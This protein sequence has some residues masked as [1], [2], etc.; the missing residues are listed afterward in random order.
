MPTASPAITSFNGGALSP[1]LAGRTDFAKY[2]NGCRDLLNFIPTVQGPA[3]QRAGTRFVSEVKN[4]ANR[5]WLARF[6]YNVDN[7]YV[8]EF[9]DLYV[10]FYTQHG[11]LESPPGTP[12]EV[13]TP[14]TL[15]SLFNADNTCRLRL[16]Q[17]G[18]FLYIF[19]GDFEPRILK[20]TSATSFTLTEY[21]PDG[22]P[23]K[24][25][26]DTAT[27]VYASAETGTGI[28]LTASAAIF[29]AGHVGS[30]FLL[31]AKS[32]NSV[33]AWEVAKAVVATDRRRVS[34]RVY[35][36]L[37]A[38]T[39]GTAQPVHTKGA[40]Y[41]GD[42][43]VQWEFRDA[44]FG[45]V[46]IT[47]IGGGGTTATVDVV[48]RLPADVVSAGNATTRWA[49]ASWSSAEGWPT[50]VAFFRERLA[51]ARRDQIWL[52]VASAFDDMSARNSNG[53]VA[54]DQAISL[55][56][57]SGE[58]NDVQWLLPGK[59]LLAGTAGGE[60][61]IGELSNGEPLGPSNIRVRLQSRF[62][63]RS[64]VPVQAGPAI[65]FVQRAGKKVRE[66]AY[67]F[68]SDGYQSTDRTALAEHITQSGLIDLDYAQEPDSVVWCARADGVLVGFTWNAEQNVWA[69]HPHSLSGQVES[70]A[71]IPSPDGSRNELWL[72]VKR[73][74]N[75]A[76]KRYVEFIEASW[77]PEQ[78]QQDAFYVDCGLGYNGAPATTISGLGHLEGQ[79]VAVLAD[80]S[81][82]PQRTVS[83]GA[84]TL[85]TA[86]S[87]VQ[88]GL[89]MTARLS[90]MR[91]DAGAATGTAQA[92]TKRT[93]RLSVRLQNTSSGKLGPDDDHLDELTFRSPS[94]PM[95][96]PV[97]AFTGDKLLSWPGGYDTDGFIL[98]VNDKPLPCT[99]VA[100][101][102]QVSTQD[103]R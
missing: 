86:A 30:P 6:E 17:S 75:G 11:R 37:N 8:I 46:R 34:Q 4:S 45:W 74:I 50:D 20:R 36:A 41:D 1:L 48:S 55:T 5:T 69:W 68:S 43:G 99:V 65:L 38:A 13:T 71:A 52:S 79:P 23:F 27:T 72:I 67:D 25:L 100:F 84:I 64:I 39:T 3:T 40:L 22:G 80:G 66:L 77:S 14:Y 101:Y 56:L 88:V 44:G 26:N 2:S 49:H 47:A 12:V 85:Q 89:P 16:S 28:T 31:E 95:D 24:A 73:T 32:T 61:S 98:F 92:K 94:D 62:G 96:E 19:H 54:A 18:D 15:A 21:R 78:D 9:G 10:R 57:A 60:F 63:S 97:P 35:E 87:V 33:K 58:I 76:V 81:P 103:A 53:E 91:G 42:T 102:P 82:H 29:L 90:P 7:A 70:V 51:A 59:D 93:S 83:G